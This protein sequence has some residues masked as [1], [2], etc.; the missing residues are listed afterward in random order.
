MYL[1][2]C[3]DLHLL[4]HNKVCIIWNEDKLRMTYLF[5]QNKSTKSFP[6]LLNELFE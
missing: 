1:F 2:F 3:H 4:M 5:N 6:S